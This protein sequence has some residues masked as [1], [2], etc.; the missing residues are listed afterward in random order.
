MAETKVT[1]DDI[2]AKLAEIQG[3]ATSTV[4]GAKSQIAAVGIG[5]AL[6]LLIV[7]FLLGRQ[8]GLK[9]NTIIEIS[10]S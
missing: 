4:Q 6:I 5:L 8:G 3:D 9:K 7:A 10:R 1:R 2:Q